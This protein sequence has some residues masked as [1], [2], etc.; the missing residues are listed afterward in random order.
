[1][2]LFPFAFRAMAASHEL[3]LGCDDEARARRAA[4]AA[5]ADVERI[6]A[7][8]SRF[9]DTSLVSA[10]NRAAG[11]EAV[12]IDAETA[13]LLRYADACHA[14]SRGRFDITSGALRRAWDFRRTPPRVPGA[15][16]IDALRALVDW[17]SVAWDERSIRLPRRGMEIDLGGV[18]KEYAADRVATIAIDLGIAH[19]FVNL[20]GDVRAWGGHPGGAPWRVGIRDPRIDGASIGGIEVVD[21]AVATS[22]DYERAFIV[23]GRRYCHILDASTGWPAEGWQSMSVVA[24][25]CVVA[26]SGATVG[27]LLGDDAP[28]W[29]DAQGFEWLGVDASG[30]LRRGGQR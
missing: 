8:Y 4:G 3:L 13:A 7:K 23:D 19:G 24:P 12:A 27:M 14:A 5:L 17:R 30:A 10:I 18:G 16:E 22:G 20:A 15:R 29:L 2:R 26:G 9:R 21:G 6:E 1:M 28:A 25:L 11:A